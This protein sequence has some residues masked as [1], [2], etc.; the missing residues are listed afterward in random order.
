[1]CGAGLV[2]R[3]LPFLLTTLSL[4]LVFLFLCP[5]PLFSIT[6]SWIGFNGAAGEAGPNH[7]QAQEAAQGLLQEDWRDGRYGANQH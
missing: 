2:R 7:P 4:S 6:L 3:G 5:P 1:M